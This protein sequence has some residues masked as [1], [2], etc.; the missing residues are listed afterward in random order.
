MI[1][2][3][4]QQLSFLRAEKFESVEIPIT[5]ATVF[6]YNFPIVGNLKDKWIAGFE[7]LSSSLSSPNNF[8]CPAAADRNRTY[9]TL[10]NKKDHTQFTRLSVFA[11][12]GQ[13]GI[14]KELDFPEI[15]WENSFIEI[16]DNPGA[17]SPAPAGRSYLFGV[18]YTERKNRNALMALV[19]K[20]TQM[21]ERM[22]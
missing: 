6:K 15:D 11:M 16:I 8:Q 1:L 4:S 17:P 19:N 20:F 3:G 21:L 2:V 7:C 13:P 9:V 22:A 10:I 12:I 18:Y 5:S 14:V